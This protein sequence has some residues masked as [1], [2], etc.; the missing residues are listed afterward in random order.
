M[1]VVMGLNVMILAP[2]MAVGGVIMALREDVPLSAILLVIVPLMGVFLAVMLSRAL[3]LFRSVQV[4]V[5]RIN[6]VVRETLSGV[7][8]IR[9]FVRTDHEEQRFDEANRDLTATTP[10]GEPLVR[11]DDPDGHGDLQ[12]VDRRDHVVRQ[13]PGGQR[14]AWPS[15][16]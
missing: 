13:H 15:G 2:I 16:T 1:L 12:P 7:R 4:K 10:P 11:P 6:Q 8:V 5:D 14:R 9:A 3:P